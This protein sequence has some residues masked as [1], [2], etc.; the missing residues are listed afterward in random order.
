MVAI[1]LSIIPGA[2]IGY[3]VAKALRRPE[4]VG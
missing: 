4:Q 3:G 1:A 2:A